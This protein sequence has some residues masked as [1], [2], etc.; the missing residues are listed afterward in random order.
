MTRVP[1]LARPARVLVALCAAAAL[2]GPARAGAPTRTEQVQTQ[3]ARAKRLTNRKH[4]HKAMKE[5][6]G[7]GLSP[8]D[9]LAKEAV[10]A[11]RDVVLRGI[12]PGYQQ[13]VVTLETA[14]SAARTHHSTHPGVRLS[15]TQ[16]SDVA[17][18]TCQTELDDLKA[19]R[20]K[21]EKT[22]PKASAAPASCKALAKKLEK[23]CFAGLRQGQV[24][25][26]CH[27]LSSLS[28]TGLKGSQLCSVGASMIP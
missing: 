20:R 18:S 4:I 12:D 25:N 6:Q 16:W 22:A 13:A 21:L 1:A 24:S 26:A 9:T 5:A 8:C 19:E 3:R 7:K 17:G 15:R 27:S 14:R 23:A 28:N 11:G 2:A 10:A